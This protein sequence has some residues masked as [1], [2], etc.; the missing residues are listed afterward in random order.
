MF[1]RFTK[2]LRQHV[3]L[4]ASVV[5]LL[6]VLVL[7]YGVRGAC[8][9]VWGMLVAMAAAL[10]GG[11]DEQVVAGV[12]WRTLPLALASAGV[13]F[14][15]RSRWLTLD[16][17]QSYL[18]VAA[19]VLGAAAVGNAC[20]EQSSRSVAVLAVKTDED[21][22]SRQQS[23]AKPVGLPSLNQGQGMAFDL[24]GDAALQADVQPSSWQQMGAIRW[25][26]KPDLAR[27]P[28]P[29]PPVR[30]FGE[31]PGVLGWIG[32]AVNQ[33]LGYL[34]TYE[35]RLFLAS[36]VAGGFVGWQLHGR[37]SKANAVIADL[38]SGNSD[39]NV[40]RKAA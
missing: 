28:Q 11:G 29:I 27:Q 7:L 26:A 39:E 34:I 5:V 1:H 15:V 38:V 6:V 19:I 40:T 36:L 31:G 2:F 14:A 10:L 21:S 32:S 35:P 13:V 4:P 33:L 30:L 22:S 23:P 8:T 3:R 37:V 24:A 17:I 12:V 18:A 9:V 25:F 20:H 16:G